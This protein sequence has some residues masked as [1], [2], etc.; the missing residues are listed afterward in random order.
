MLADFCGSGTAARIECARVTVPGLR[1]R[2]LV[3]AGLGFA[4]L[5]CGGSPNPGSPSPPSSN[6]TVVTIGLNGVSPKDVQIALG[7][8][9]R[10][11]NSDTQPHN[12]GSDPHP[13]HGDC[14]DINQVGYLLP[15]QSRETGNFVQARACGFHDHDNPLVAS[16][17]GSITAR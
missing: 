3:V 17:K 15:G 1:R 4:L 11:V 9:V 8:R 6:A 5:A 10:F 13:E 14:P 7:G 2:G 16:L 12:V